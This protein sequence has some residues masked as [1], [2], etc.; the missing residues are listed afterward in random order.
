MY[1]RFSFPTYNMAFFLDQS[2]NDFKKTFLEILRIR[3]VISSIW[4]DIRLF[5]IR[6]DNRK[7]KFCIQPDTGYH[8][9]RI[10]WPAGYPVLP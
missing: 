6:P 4:P 8:K 5:S 1:L 2:R 7:F 10:I 9:G 3:M